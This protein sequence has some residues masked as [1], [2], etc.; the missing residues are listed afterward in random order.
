MVMVFCFLNIFAV[1]LGRETKSEIILRYP[2]PSPPLSW[3]YWPGK[4]R[5]MWGGRAGTSHRDKVALVSPDVHH[6]TGLVYWWWWWWEAV[7]NSLAPTWAGWLT[8]QLHHLITKYH[9][10]LLTSHHL[11]PFSKNQKIT[12]KHKRIIRDSISRALVGV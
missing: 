4:G 11:P 10:S 9:S 12:Q 8:S 5:R 2:P 1:L 3:S 6:Y 7:K